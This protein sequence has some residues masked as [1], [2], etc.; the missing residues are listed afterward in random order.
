MKLLKIIN[1][2][3]ALEETTSEVLFESDSLDVLKSKG[4]EY[5]EGQGHKNRLWISGVVV[6]DTKLSEVKDWHMHLTDKEELFIDE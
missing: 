6:G 1:K 4:M 3:I 5:A 2:G